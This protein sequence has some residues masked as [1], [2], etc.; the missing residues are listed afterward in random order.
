METPIRVRGGAS[1]FL[2]KSCSICIHS[3]VYTLHGKV[4][5]SDWVDFGMEEPSISD[6][7]AELK[8]QKEEIKEL[9]NFKVSGLREE[10]QSASASANSEL[11]KF[12][13]QNEITW[14]SKGQK[15]STILKQIF[16]SL[17]IL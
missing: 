7:L 2:G 1:G 15:F 16:K 13:G 5:P 10:I 14:R 12:K 6:L 3:R 9:V 11:K 8:S 4:A 17:W